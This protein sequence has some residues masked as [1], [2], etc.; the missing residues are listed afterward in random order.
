MHETSA[1]KAHR[2]KVPLGLQVVAS[3]S[4]RCAS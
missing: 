2:K 1:Q 4:V 3:G